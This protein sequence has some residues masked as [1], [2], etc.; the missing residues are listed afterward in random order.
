M[1]EDTCIHIDWHWNNN[2]VNTWLMLDTLLIVSQVLISSYIV[3]IDWHQR[4]CLGKLAH[5]QPMVGKD[6]NWVSIKEAIENWSSV[7]WGSF[8]V[9]NWVYLDTHSYGSNNIHMIDLDNI[10]TWL[11][12]LSKAYTINFPSVKLCT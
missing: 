11:L 8:K 9:I 3:C 1:R 2:S 5:S 10:F 12:A 4:A 6:V 7:N